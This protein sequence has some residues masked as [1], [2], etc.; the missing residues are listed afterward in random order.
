MR[1]IAGLCLPRCARSAPC[2]RPPTGSYPQSEEELQR[3]FRGL[4]WRAEP[5]SYK[6][7]IP[8]P[9]SGCAPAR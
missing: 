5:G 9:W 2:P 8:M 4:N 6:L 1:F 3:A 7:P